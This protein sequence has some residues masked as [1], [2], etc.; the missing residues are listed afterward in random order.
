MTTVAAAQTNG[1][2]RQKLTL[3]PTE[4]ETLFE[5]I[6][7]DGRADLLALEPVARKLLIYRQRQSGF[8]N[9][10]DQIISLPPQ[11]GWIGV[12]DVDPHPGV[13]LVMSTATGLFY[14]RQQNG[15]FESEPRSLLKASQV[16]TNVD[17]PALFSLITNRMLPV[18]SSNETVWYQRNDAFEWSPGQ[19]IP[20][21][22]RHSKWRRTRS[23]WALGANSSRH[24][25]VLESFGS[26]SNDAANE[27]AETET[28][29]KLLGGMKMAG[30]SNGLGTNQVDLDGNGRT[31]LVLWQAEGDQ[32][33]KADIYV[34]LRGA[35]GQ[36]PERPT[37]VVHS[38]GIPIPFGSPFWWLPVCD[39]R[40]DGQHQLVLLELKST[41]TSA[42]SLVEALVSHGLEWALTIREFHNGTFSRSP[43]AAI[44]LTLTLSVQQLRE[45]PLF[46]CGDFN[47]DGRPDFVVQRSTTQWNIFFST[48]DG[49]WF[50]SQPS[51]TFET[52]IPGYF[53][54]K[55][56]NGDGR[57]DIVLRGLDE[58]TMYIY[59]TQTTRDGGKS[60]SP[61]GRPPNPKQ[62]SN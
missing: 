13:E 57:S 39:L 35:N 51:M 23:E 43:D 36:F 1:F 14:Y 41:F 10:P 3:P 20:L 29:R 11:T 44:P 30:Q 9:A 6:D 33:P 42:S 19:T 58:P 26:I 45:W 24:L 34:F 60:E 2:L 7:N 31:D 38:R 54:L 47:G 37:Q 52:P 4:G 21:T 50:A 62:N 17:S 15:V 48:S 16:L 5:D 46:I 40:R 56:L 18:I 12:C 22:L 59:L 49:H 55:D 27:K 28:I 53:E 8:T 32:E 25:R 61:G